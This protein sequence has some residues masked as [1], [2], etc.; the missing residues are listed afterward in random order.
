MKTHS[1]K[2]N[3]EREWMCYVYDVNGNY[4]LGEVSY[5]GESRIEVSPTKKSA[6]DR[7]MNG[8]TESQRKWTIHGHPLKD[9]KIYTGRQYF[10][11]TD[12]CREFVKSYQNDEKV[13]QFLVYPHKQI[14]TN[15][16]E[17][18]FHNRCRI[19]VFPNR[20]TLAKAMRMS[21]P[22]VDSSRI[23]PETGQNQQVKQQDG[24]MTLANKAGVDWFAFQESMGQLGCMGI[25]D[26]EGPKSGS[27]VFN[28]EGRI[29][30]GNFAGIAAIGVILY[31]LTKL[32]KINIQ[33]AE[34]IQVVD[35][36]ASFYH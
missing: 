10:S 19:L 1:D 23:T 2:T 28:S 8:Y 14:D 24:S 11:S 29:R 4:E 16:G 9:G 6:Q 33:N 35:D 3:D 25:I 32:R 34:T 22:S 30:M 12:I 17:E 5:G 13:V 7:L 21:N 26:L 20:E 15:T 31:G 36:L 27:T 18:V